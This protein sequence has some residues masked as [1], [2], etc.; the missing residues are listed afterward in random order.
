MTYKPGQFGYFTILSESVPAETHPFSIASTP[1]EPEHLTLT[2]K[3]LGDF[4]Q[5]I[6]TVKPGDE[7]IVDGPYGNF[8]YLNYPQEKASVFVA[9]GVGITPVLSMVKHM[10]EKDP[11][12]PV[13][14]IWGVR[15]PADMIQRQEL[16]ALER[17]MPNFNWVPV[18]SSDD[19]WS[20][21][22]GVIDLNTLQHI[23]G[24]SSNWTSSTGFFLCGPPVMMTAT[25][26]NLKQLGI[27]N[28]QIHFESFSA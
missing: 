15:T 1:T 4:T 25:Q 8:S 13:T 21:M 9:G 17:T 10:K 26:K 12:R 20:G 23:L 24:E 6:A 22:K 27:A 3:Q 19:N 7:V 14:L 16:L 28:K 5:R 18:V 11:D 2:I